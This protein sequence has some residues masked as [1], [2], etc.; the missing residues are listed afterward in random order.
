MTISLAIASG[1][2]VLF[3]A[4]VGFVVS[5][6]AKSLRPRARQT[7]ATSVPIVPARFADSRTAGLVA[8]AQ[9]TWH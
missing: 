1:V 7:P 3:A 9:V 8:D 5:Q 4:L 6:T 2:L